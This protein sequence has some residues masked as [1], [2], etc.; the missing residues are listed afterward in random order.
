MYAP[1]SHTEVCGPPVEMQ[2]LYEVNLNILFLYSA[3]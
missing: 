3:M 1:N 2:N